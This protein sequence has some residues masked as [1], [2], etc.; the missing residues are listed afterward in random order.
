MGE[1]LAENLRLLCSGYRSVS[2]ACRE[3]G[4]NRQQ[5]ARYL[6]GTARP[7]NHNLQR[8]AHG[9]GISVDDLLNTKQARGPKPS[10]HE[11]SFRSPVGRMID[12]VFPGDLQ[13]LR[14]L[15][16]Y[17]H[18]HFLVPYS[19]GHV[20]RSLTHIYE[21]QGKILSKTIE[22]SPGS[23]ETVPQLSKYA[24]LVSY[25]GNCIFI[26]EFETLSE[27]SLVE[28]ML[29]PSYRKRLDILT[30]LTFG[31]TSQVHREPFASPI[32]FKYLGPVISVKEQMR[33]CGLFSMEDRGI[34]PRIR[35]Y[36]QSAKFT[37]TLSSSPA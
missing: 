7:S 1:F 15:L 14:Q 3:L 37:G 12:R 22:R 11:L 10:P 19:T 26:M 28:S 18:M 20:K 21:S 8:I 34:D 4:F 2:E 36:L 9:L 30:G 23:A 29:F 32:A 13:K 24:G 35:R 31:V 27:D 17:Y 6:T 33:S 25:L 5:F 16:G